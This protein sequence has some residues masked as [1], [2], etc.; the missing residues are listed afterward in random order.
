MTYSTC[1]A[2]ERILTTTAANNIIKCRLQTNT[3]SFFVL[4]IQPWKYECPSDSA[5]T[6]IR[7]WK[8]SELSFETWTIELQI[9]PFLF[10][11]KT[12]LM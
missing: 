1:N 3:A 2:S 5:T 11:Q 8:S 7:C 10:R 12:P 9:Q 6:A 4:F